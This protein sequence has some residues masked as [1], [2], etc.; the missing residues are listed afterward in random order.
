[1]MNRTE[2]LAAPTAGAKNGQHLSSAHFHRRAV[3]RPPHCPLFLNPQLLFSLDINLVFATAN[4]LLGIPAYL[5]RPCF[6]VPC[7]HAARML[8]V[9]KTASSDFRPKKRCNMQPGYGSFFIRV[10]VIGKYVESCSLKIFISTYET[11]FLLNFPCLLFVA[12]H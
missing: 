9:Q 6:V 10:D 2:T 7:L 12:F 5:H 1:M 4:C 8:Q 11:P 3:S